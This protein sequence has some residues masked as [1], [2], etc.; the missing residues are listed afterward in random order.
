[1]YV[2]VIKT[3]RDITKYLGYYE[4]IEWP[5]SQSNLHPLLG[6][7]SLCGDYEFQQYNG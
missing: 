1:M 3:M 6:R 4:I 5:T 2:G 7:F